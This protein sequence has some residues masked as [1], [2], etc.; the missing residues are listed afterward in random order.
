MLC[1]RDITDIFKTF[2]EIYL[3]FTSK[4]EISSI[5]FLNLVLTTNPVV[6]FE[7]LW[8][9]L[10]FFDDVTIFLV[11][12]TLIIY[13]L[14]SGASNT[15]LNINIIYIC[16]KGNSFFHA[17]NQISDKNSDFTST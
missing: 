7:I 4:K 15:Q 9:H 8:R 13:I 14:L 2:D 5:Y 3:L 17:I 1:T 10:R 16:E 6:K 11:F 12:S